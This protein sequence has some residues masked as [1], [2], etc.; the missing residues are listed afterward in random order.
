MDD[1]KYRKLKGQAAA[2]ETIRQHLSVRP[3]WCRLLGYK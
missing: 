2:A 3:L 1:I